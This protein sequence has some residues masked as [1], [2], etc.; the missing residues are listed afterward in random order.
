[1]DLAVGDVG[2]ILSKIVTTSAAIG[3]GI[4]G[5]IIAPT[6]VIGAVLGGALGTVGHS[7]VPAVSSDSGHYAILGMGAMMGATLQAPLAALIAVFE[8]TQNPHIIMP[9]MLVIVVA[10]LISGR[11]FGCRSVFRVLLKA[12]GLDYT[13]DPVVQAM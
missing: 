1:M 5:G 7:V 12:R 11:L 6:L 13:H 4:P 10:N 8:L 9:G 3:L 2:I